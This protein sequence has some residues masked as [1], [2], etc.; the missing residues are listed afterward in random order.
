M[1]MLSFIAYLTQCVHINNEE[2]LD[3]IH[4]F[5]MHDTVSP[6]NGTGLLVKYYL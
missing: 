4:Q 3:F 2:T 6:F 5:C 1:L